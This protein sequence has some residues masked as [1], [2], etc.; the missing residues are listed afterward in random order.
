MSSHVVLPSVPIRA[1]LALLQAALAQAGWIGALIGFIALTLT[2]PGGDDGYYFYLRPYWSGATAPAWVFL[3]TAS[4]VP[5]MWPL[6]WTAIVIVSVL[7]AVWA[8]RAVG[9]RRWWILL[10]SHAFVVNLWMG[11]IELFPIA[12]IGLAWLVLQRKIHPAWFGITILAL[13]TKVQVGAGLA[14]LFTF[15]VWREQGLRPLIWAAAAALAV[16]GVTLLFYPAWPIHYFE[17]LGALAPQDQ[18]WNASIFPLGLLTIPLAFYPGDVGKIRRARMI[19]C[20]TLL[21]SP[22]FAWYHP[23]AAL[24]LETRGAM[25]WLSWID[26][27]PRVLF[28]YKHNG[29]VVLLIMLGWDVWQIWRERRKSFVLNDGTIDGK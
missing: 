5:L 18:V 6:R 2:M 11:Q 4:T 17:A 19:A 26:A 1:R 7:V 10:F 9:D 16:I 22:Y 15:W 24:L 27:L 3:F 21:A 28:D 13:M 23:S 20:I 29:W 14:L 8:R 12:G 25:M